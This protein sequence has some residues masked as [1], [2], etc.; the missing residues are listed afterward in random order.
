MKATLLAVCDRSPEWIDSGYSDYVDRLRGRLQLDYRRIKLAPRG[1]GRSDAD[2]RRDESQRL[3]AAVPDGAWRVALDSRGRSWSSEQL[4]RELERWRQSGQS[5]CLLIGGPD[6][7]L[8]EDRARC[9]QCWS[10]GAMTLPHALVRVIVAEQLYRAHCI[11]D[12]HPY[13]R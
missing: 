13:H 9:E 11:L 6:G 1:K 5:L 7:L 4:A 8:D 10:L 12:G 3:L 2:A